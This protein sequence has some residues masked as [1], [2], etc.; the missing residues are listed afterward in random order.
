MFMGATH[1]PH[2]C[3]DVMFFNVQRADR[4]ILAIGGGA[5]RVMSCL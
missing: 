4:F 2:G 3:P 1:D 5:D